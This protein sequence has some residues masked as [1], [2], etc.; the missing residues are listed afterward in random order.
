[1]SVQ[2]NQCPSSAVS[3]PHVRRLTRL[4]RG[5]AQ[6]NRPDLLPIPQK[7]LTLTRPQ[8]GRLWLSF[9]DETDFTESA[10]IEF[11]FRESKDTFS[12]DDTNCIHATL[13]LRAVPLATVD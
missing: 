8:S 4:G 5:I 10:L 9:G 2:E 6:S 3:C 13:C 11:I 7:S 12:D 1:M